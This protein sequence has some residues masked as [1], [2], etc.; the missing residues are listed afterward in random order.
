[1]RIVDIERQIDG[2][3]AQIVKRRIPQSGAPGIMRRS[4]ADDAGDGFLADGRVIERIDDTILN[5]R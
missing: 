2:V 5:S 3:D 1:M 4:I